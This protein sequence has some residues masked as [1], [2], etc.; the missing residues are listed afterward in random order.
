MSTLMTSHNNDDLTDVEFDFVR[1]TMLLPNRK[2]EPVADAAVCVAVRDT[3]DRHVP[4]KIDSPFLNLCSRIFRL[5]DLCTRSNRANSCCACLP[6][7]L[8][9]QWQKTCRRRIQ[10]VGR[11]SAP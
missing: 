10:T 4:E 11:R 7:T 5:I 1:V 9:Y 3:R 8:R 2:S 6:G